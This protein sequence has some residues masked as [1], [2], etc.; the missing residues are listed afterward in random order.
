MKHLDMRVVIGIGFVLTAIS[1][2][3]MT[4]FNMQMNSATVVWSGVIQGVGMGGR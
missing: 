2:W 3:Q 4:G 1:L